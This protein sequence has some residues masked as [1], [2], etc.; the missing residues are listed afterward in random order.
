MPFVRVWIHVVW[1]TKNRQ[2]FLKTEI[3]P[4]VFEHIKKNAR[5]KNIVIDSIGG[6]TDHVHCLIS[7]GVDQSISKMMQLLKGESSFWINRNRITRTKFGWQEEYFA[8]SV[9][10]S[11]VDLVRKYIAN[12]VRH[13][14]KITFAEEFDVFLKRTGFD[15]R[16]DSGNF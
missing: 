14:S 12:Q 2:P 15:P 11:N 8:A 5:S 3:R 6:Y 10:E 7:Y 1:S 4:L 16:D 9:S 13:H